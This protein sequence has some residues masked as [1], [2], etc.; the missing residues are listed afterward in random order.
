[1]KI[2]FKPLLWYFL[3][4]AG[5]PAN[6]QLPEVGFIIDENTAIV[7]TDPQIDF[8]SPEG[9]NLETSWRECN[10]K[11]YGAAHRGLVPCSSE[12]QYAYIC[13][14]TLLLSTRP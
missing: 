13:I 3:L 7:I 12:K 5:L 9:G 11:Q 6:A 8:L 14:S 2:I 10:G 1:M 4:F